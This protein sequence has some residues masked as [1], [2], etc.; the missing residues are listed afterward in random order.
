M[1]LVDIAISTKCIFGLLVHDATAAALQS[2]KKQ[3][4]FPGKQLYLELCKNKCCL[5]GSRMCCGSAHMAQLQSALILCQIRGLLQ[6]I[7]RTESPPKNFRLPTFKG[8]LPNKSMKVL[9]LISKMCILWNIFQVYHFK[10]MARCYVVSTTTSM[11][12]N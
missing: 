1:N 9:P 8:A 11:L 7:D 5:S 2:R 4:P 10:E 6:S 12:K 3:I